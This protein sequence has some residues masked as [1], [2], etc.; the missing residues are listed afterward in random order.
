MEEEGSRRGGR[1]WRKKAQALVRWKFVIFHER[2]IWNFEGNLGIF[3]RLR[4]MGGH[5]FYAI[6]LRYFEF[7]ILFVLR[8]F[9][10]GIWLMFDINLLWKWVSLERERKRKDVCVTE[11]EERL[12]VNDRHDVFQNIIRCV[13]LSDGRIKY[14]YLYTYISL[15]V[16]CSLYK[17]QLN[18]RVLTSRIDNIN[19]SK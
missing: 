14:S 19:R 13:F 17:L 16:R 5:F 1:R 8:D 12:F 2:K 9:H 3:W 11:W 7:H 10:V 6:I 15:K 18:L 4:N